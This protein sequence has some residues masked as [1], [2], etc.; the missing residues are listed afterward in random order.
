MKSHKIV[1]TPTATKN[2]CKAF[3]TNQTAAMHCLDDPL[4]YMRERS[5]SRKRSLR[6]RENVEWPGDDV[7]DAGLAEPA[8]GEVHLTSR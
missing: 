2:N 3:A 7:L 1:N 8:L 4:K 5:S 6:G